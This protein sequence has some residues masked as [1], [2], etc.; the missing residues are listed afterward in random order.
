MDN[1]AMEIPVS[2]DTYQAFLRMSEFTGVSVVNFMAFVLDDYGKIVEKRR[3][4]MQ[5]AAQELI[6]TWTTASH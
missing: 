5:V 4:D 6:D 3:N 1:V 2:R